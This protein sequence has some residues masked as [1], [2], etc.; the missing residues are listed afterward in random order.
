MEQGEAVS[1]REACRRLELSEKTL[2]KRIRSGQIEAWEIEGKCG[3][4]WRVR[5]GPGLGARCSVL[6][7]EGTGEGR[8]ERE[9]RE[10]VRTTNLGPESVSL[11]L[12]R[13]LLARHEAATVRL[14]YLQAQ[15]ERLPELTQGAAAAAQREQQARERAAQAGALSCRLEGRCRQLGAAILALVLLVVA[16]GLALLRAGAPRPARPA[17]AAVVDPAQR[18]PNGAYPAAA[19]PAGPDGRARAAAAGG[20]P[21]APPRHAPD[22]SADRA[23]E[24]SSARYSR[25]Y[26]PGGR[27]SG[28][29]ARP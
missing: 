17:G 20:G 5:V 16:L 18:L 19:G 24:G 6:G 23:G 9:E 1:F 15:L 7:G 12:Y 10:T 13:E 28:R 29:P 11:S 26:D 3:R 27:T 14:G 4:E 25:D 8:E 2:R 21:H 22:G